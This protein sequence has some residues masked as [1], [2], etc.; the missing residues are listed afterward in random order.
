MFVEHP[1]P[2]AFALMR[3]TPGHDFEP[4]GQLGLE[5]LGLGRVLFRMGLARHLQART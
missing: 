1:H 3:L 4:R 2:H 5:G